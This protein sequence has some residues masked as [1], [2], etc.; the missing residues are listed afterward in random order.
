M[1][2]GLR[3]TTF[4]EK[5]LKATYH[6]DS[7]AAKSCFEESQSVI[8]VKIFTLHRAVV[9]SY[10]R[11]FEIPKQVTLIARARH[12][13]EKSIYI[14]FECLVIVFSFIVRFAQL[15]FPNNGIYKYKSILN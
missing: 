2:Y 12:L 14:I 3:L 11:V 4:V 6:A 9:L 1:M 8:G 10:Q 7:P 15:F 5:H 13:S